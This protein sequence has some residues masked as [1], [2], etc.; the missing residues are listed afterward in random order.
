MRKINWFTRL[1]MSWSSLEAYISSG[2]PMEKNE[3]L[4]VIKNAHEKIS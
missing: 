1:F 2:T 4:E 3:S